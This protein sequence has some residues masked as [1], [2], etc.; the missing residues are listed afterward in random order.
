MQSHEDLRR[1]V[2]KREHARNI[3]SGA[4]GRIEREAQAFLERFAPGKQLE[5]VS[6]AR[7]QITI[8]DDGS[9]VSLTY[10][11]NAEEENDGG[12]QHRA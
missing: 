4:I 9:M 11:L 6:R 2:E 5:I 1:A 3:V 12:G 10:Q 7:V 8:D